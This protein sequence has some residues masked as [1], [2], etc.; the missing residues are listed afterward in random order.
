M[1]KE[2]QLTF[3]EMVDQFLKGKNESKES[4][5]GILEYFF[6]E[7][8]GK[9][10]RNSATFSKLMKGLDSELK[11][12]KLWI[13]RYTTLVSCDKDF[14]KLV[15]GVKEVVEVNGKSVIVSRV[16]LVDFYNGQK[17]YEQKADKES[18]DYVLKDSAESFAKKAKKNGVSLSD[19]IEAVKT[20][21]NKQ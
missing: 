16:K 19:M 7:Y 17:W 13:A 18:K 9:L 14:T 3:D 21:Y 20:A 5:Q 11:Q 2:K 1:T 6:T 10:S 12:V 15:G 4:L 8:E